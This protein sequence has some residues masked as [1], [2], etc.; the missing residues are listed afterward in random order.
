MHLA[1]VNT[2]KELLPL[3]RSLILSNYDQ[4]LGQID[5]LVKFNGIG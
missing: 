5:V 2:I 1:A 4:M 3:E